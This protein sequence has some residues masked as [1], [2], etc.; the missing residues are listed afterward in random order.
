MISL[1]QGE[2][3]TQQAK[4]NGLLKI[5]YYL[6]VA[7]Y[8]IPFRIFFCILVLKLILFTYITSLGFG[9]FFS[10]FGII[11]ITLSLSLLVG[12]KVFKFIYL[13]SLDILFS[14]VF[15]INSLYF[16]YFGSFASLYD[17]HQAHQLRTVIDV[18][19]NMIGIDAL[20]V[21]DI[22]IL[23]LLFLKTKLINKNFSDRLKALV[24]LLFLGLYCVITPLLLNKKFSINFLKFI[25][26]GY[27]FT[28]YLGIINYQTLD[29]YNYI[30][31][32]T[33]KQIVKEKDIDSVKNWYKEKSNKKI[34]HNSTWGKNLNL[35]IIQVESL[36]NFVIGRKYN[37]KEITP[38]LNRLAR[39]GIYFKNIYDQ[40]AAGNTSD[41]TFLANSSLYP[42]R[43]GAVSFLYPQNCFDSIPKVLREKGYTTAIMHA[44]D[45]NF[46]NRAKFDKTLGFEYQ[47]YE[48]DYVMTEKI[49]SFLVGLSDKA[50]FAQ[51][52]DK[53]KKLKSPFYVLLISLS[54][55]SV[56]AHITPDMVNFPLG[57][58][59]GEI[60]GHYMRAIH[61]TDSAIGEFLKKLSENN[62][63]SNTVIVVYGDHRARL[64]ES[65]LR[66][67]GIEDMTEL[68]K[69]PLIISIPGKKV[70]ET[71]NTI[72]GLIDVAP[73]IL[74]ILGIDASDRFFMGRDLLNGKQGFVIFRDGSY[75]SDSG[76]INKAF[77]EK[78]LM[79]SDLII[80]K[81]IIPLIRKE[82]KCN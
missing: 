2:I 25:Y 40:T 72:G 29:A 55:H 21:I 48:N 33:K 38:N 5:G 68:R 22:P 39:K 12:N 77:V 15:F 80:E 10:S 36:Q 73:T 59:E 65:E 31:T 18:V 82:G 54:S 30:L 7:Y 52:I 1:N 13:F 44:Y 11:L 24:I 41:A 23:S 46:W 81:D 78:Q 50:F 61:Y 58:L 43:K 57:N 3:L 42:L 63:L 74:N 27:E 49:G 16:K 56:F 71:R 8:E 19:A 20:F 51:S 53:L 26:S 34:K 17:L 75:I 32:K 79:V 35:I 4:R 6:S 45:K 76:N 62:L 37:G 47:F 64:P 69:I 67:I 14:L 28:T 60:I 9:S 70:G 66:R